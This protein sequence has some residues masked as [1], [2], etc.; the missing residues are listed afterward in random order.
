MKPKHF[1]EQLDEGR[2]LAAI[3]DAE[4]KSSGEIRVYVSHR[5]RPEPLAYA[6]KRFE[7]LGLTRTRERNAVLIYLAPLSHAYAIVGD[8]GVHEKC[9]DQFWEGLAAR[10]KPLLS[11]GRYTDALVAAIGVV[12]AV[13]A[14]HFPRQPDD[15]NELPNQIL[16]D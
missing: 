6:R 9:G 10:M 2:L 4:R 14:R 8:T 5:R 3:A 13:L 7:Q 1:I 12:G 11:A 15:R 16:G